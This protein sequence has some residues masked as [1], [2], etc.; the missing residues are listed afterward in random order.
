[1]KSKR[2]P[3]AVAACSQERDQH[4]S[5]R[6]N[7]H[8]GTDAEQQRLT[9]REGCPGAGP[10][11]D[12]HVAEQHDD[13]HDIVG[14][15]SPHHRPEAITRVEY[16]PGQYMYAVEEDLWHAV[17]GKQDHRLVLTRQ[18]WRFPSGR[19]IQ[20]DDRRHGEREQQRDQAQSD[21][22]GGH[23][24][25]GVRIAAIFVTADGT[26]DL[27]DEDSVQYAPGQ[28]DVHAVRHGGGDGEHLRLPG[29]VAKQ[30]H[31]QHEAEKP[32]HSGQGSTRGHQHTGRHQTL[33][34]PALLRRRP[35]IVADDAGGD[36][37]PAPSRIGFGRNDLG[38]RGL[39]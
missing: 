9:C 33:G 14:D 21:Q 32:H 16:L 5:L 10:I 19:G 28:Q 13:R 3:E 26:H 24:P 11:E 39:C 27:R 15:R 18:L 1:L 25:I 23:D 38:C 12:D 17:V 36:D 20:P 30:V 4:G 7:A 8:R 6:G 37:P 34:L 22:A 35:G 31:Q 2:G 29:A